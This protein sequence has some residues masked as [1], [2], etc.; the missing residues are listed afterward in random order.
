MSSDTS[1]TIPSSAR[2]SAPRSVP[3]RSPNQPSDLEQMTAQIT[4]AVVDY[5]K[6][7]PGAVA[8]LIFMVGF[9]MGW[10]IKPW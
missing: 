9:F 10:K 2:S 1:Q 4:D 7:Q 6:K 3:T 8:C 5:S